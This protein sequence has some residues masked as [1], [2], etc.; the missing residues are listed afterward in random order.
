MHYFIS[1]YII[2]LE[3]IKLANLKSEQIK[4]DLTLEINQDE[5]LSQK[6]IRETLINALG[7]D[8]CYFEKILNKNILHYKHDNKIEVILPASITYLGGNGQHPIYKKRMQLKKWFKNIVDLYQNDKTYN[9][10]FLGVYHYQENII[11]TDFIKDSYIKKKMNSSAAHVF[12][13]DLYQALK[14][15]IFKREDRNH[16]I[17]ITIKHSNL[18]DYLDGLLNDTNELIELI[19]E[20][21]KSQNFNEWITSMKAIPEM[22]QNGWNK[23]KET[24]WAGWYLEYK[25]NEFIKSKHI[26]NKI[27]YVGNLNKKKGELDFDLWFNK[28]NFYGDL[29]ASQNIQKEAP[30]N[31]QEKFINCV[32]KYDKFWYILYEHDT[33]RDSEKTNYEAT[34]HRAH[35]LLDNNEWD[36]KKP[37][38][39]LSYHGRMKHS[40]KFTKMKIIELN[41][42]NYREILKDFNQG[43]QQNGDKRKPK[44]KINKRN[45]ENFTIYEEEFSNN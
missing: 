40:V 32:N 31:D 30:G 21:N 6:Q 5:P 33:I 36:K 42:I 43:K 3:G 26:E 39:E 11:F 23:F 28:N 12:T 29:K 16:N 44:F 7:K 4:K 25:Y 17:L 1:R 19:K 9:V 41:K 27:K 8:N 20:F 24:E 22:H 38:D 35:Y 34:K 14:E 2:K 15:G 10:R 37:F 18:K 13:N 45:A